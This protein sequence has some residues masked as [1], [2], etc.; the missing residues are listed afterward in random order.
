M[1]SILNEEEEYD[2]VD[3]GGFRFLYM[4]DSPAIR[5]RIA[6]I[7]VC[8]TLYNTRNTLIKKSAEGNT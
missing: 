8:G 1:T 2:Y 7:E 4:Q 3:V 5:A 6:K